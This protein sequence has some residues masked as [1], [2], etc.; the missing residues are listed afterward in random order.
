MNSIFSKEPVKRAEKSI[1]E[2]DT[3]LNV[4]VLEQTARTANDAAT[5]LGCKVGAI[6]KSLLFKAGEKFVLCLVSGD[7]RCSLN[8]LKK[9]LHEKDVSMASPEDVK[10]VTGY[11]IGGVSPV[12]HFIK[13]IIYIDENLKNFNSLFAAAGHPN[14]VFEIDFQNLKELTLGEIKEITEWEN[15][16]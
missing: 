12:G 13:T 11:T 6:V 2:F 1:K 16:S 7:K 10:R 14:A 4:I 8:K 5:A 9:I 15:H 3:N